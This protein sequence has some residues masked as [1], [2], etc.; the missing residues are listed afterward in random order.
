MPP[1]PVGTPGILNQKQGAKT[2]FEPLLWTSLA[3]TRIPVEKV[4][5]PM[6]DIMGLLRDFRRENKPLTLAARI[7]GPAETAF[8]D[9]APKD[10]AAEE[11]KDEAKPEEPK[12]EEPKAEHIAASKGPISVIVVADTDI[13]DDRFWA[14]TQEFFGQRVVIPSA[15]NGDF[16]ANAVEVLAGGVELVTLRSRGTSTRPFE[17]VQ[18]IQRGAEER[19]SAKE[20]ELQDKL[21]EI[22]GK[23]KDVRLVKDGQGGVSLTTEQAKAIENFRT[24]MLQTRQQLREVQLGMR[25]DIDRLKWRLQFVNIALVPIVVALVAIVLGLL[26]LRRRARR[27]AA[28]G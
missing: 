2:Q 14:Q 26:R 5:A 3:S 7:T 23:M 19:F 16:V 25:Q 27:Y 10:K 17:V 15:G 6:P 8:P 18:D 9:G 12:K 20:K 21:K 24:E 1:L 22:E 11:K 28:A 13:L 4:Q